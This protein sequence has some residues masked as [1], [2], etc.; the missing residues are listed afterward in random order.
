MAHQLDF[1]NKEH[2]IKAINLIDRKGV[3][4]SNQWSEYWTC[5][6]KKKIVNHNSGLAQVIMVSGKIRQI[7]RMISLTINIGE[8]TMT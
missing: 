1:I 4:K 2:I 7:C 6:N 8:L 3:P 5:H